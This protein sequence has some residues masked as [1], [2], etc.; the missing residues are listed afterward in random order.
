MDDRESLPIEHGGNLEQA[1]KAFPEAD[2]PWIDLSTGI[3][4]HPYPRIKL[5]ESAMTRLPE[6]ARIAELAEIAARTYG[7]REAAQVVPTPGTQIPTILA[8][9]LA[10]P[11][12]ARILGPTYAEHVRCAR[13]AGHEVEVVDR[14]EALAG[15]DL[16]IVVNPN[17]PDGHLSDR[18]ALLAIANEMRKRAGILIVDEAYMDVCDPGCSLAGDADSGNLVVLRSFGKFYGLAGIRLGFAIA[19]P[20]LAQRIAAMLGPW[21]ISGIALE[22]GIQALA[23]GPWRNNTRERLRLESERLDGLLR[24]CDLEPESGTSLFRYVACKNAGE[25]H[26]SLG[27][28]GILVR[29]FAD[30]P[31][32]L[33]FGLP[34]GEV[35]FSRLSNALEAAM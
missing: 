24:R 16:A 3:N 21:A 17:N 5:T 23:D 12:E 34:G 14:I 26:E 7:A 22:Y 6:R 4:P 1:R 18:S 29:R 33:R 28:R 19:Q 11:G 27:Q 8:A 2:L 32:F 9:S 13:L 20:R 15:A 10:A 30:Q 31:R 25:L 35:E